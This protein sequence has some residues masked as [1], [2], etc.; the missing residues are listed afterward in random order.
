MAYAKHNKEDIVASSN[1][2]DL[3]PYCNNNKIP[4]ITTTDF[5]CRA[6]SKN[7]YSE[8]DCDQ[9]IK[10]VLTE[11]SNLPIKRMQYYDC[12]KRKVLEQFNKQT[13]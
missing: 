1:I 3:L 8:T 7:L 4:Y 12:S 9:F 11:G 5:L 10:K 6:I 2:N 13:F